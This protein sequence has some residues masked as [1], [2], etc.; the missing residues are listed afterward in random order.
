MTGEALL[1]F[2]KMPDSLPIYSALEHRLL[3]TYPDMTV[4]TQKTQISFYDGFCFGCASL[5]R[6]GKGLL[7]TFGLLFR[8]DGDRIYVATEPYPGRWTHH[9]IVKDTHE[10]DAELLSWMDMAHEFAL[11]KGKKK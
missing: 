3:N 7:V 8:L 5:P 10:I 1:F 2:D 11:R 6:K 9:V 4:K